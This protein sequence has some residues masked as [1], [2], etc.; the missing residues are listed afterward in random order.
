[1][2]DQELVRDPLISEELGAQN[3]HMLIT[4]TQRLEEARS[5]VLANPRDEEA[6]KTLQYLLSGVVKRNHLAVDELLVENVRSIAVSGE[7]GL[8]AQSRQ[9]VRSYLREVENGLDW[10]ADAAELDS[11]HDIA[12]RMNLVRKMKQN[13]GRT[14]LMLSGGKWRCRMRTQTMQRTEQYYF[15]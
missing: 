1:M 7:Y 6:A 10:V 9:I 13:M 8:S 4:T 11:I 14:A 5:A 15:L 12:D 2:T 3:A